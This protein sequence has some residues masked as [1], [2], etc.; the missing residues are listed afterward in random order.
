MHSSI[1]LLA[2]AVFAAL[3]IGQ[4][5]AA[6]TGLHSTGSDVS[7]GIDQAWTVDGGPAYVIANPGAIGW[8]GN[9][10]SS[11]WIS[12]DPSTFGGGGP[13]TYSTTFTATAGKNVLQG[14][15]AADDQGAIYL[16]GNLVFTGDG[17]NL[18]P[19]GYFQS[20]QITTGFTLGLN[21]LSVL[22]PNNIVG[23]NDGPTGLQLTAVPEL[24]T[25]AMMLAGFA[26]L[27]FVGY[28]RQKAT[29]AA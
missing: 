20:F 12:N 28:R 8:V 11:S 7:G 3:S 4:A 22:V 21:T 24:S 15:I 25:W 27:G 6:I 2:G 29:V 19:W 1:K 10:A 23:A 9:T 26:G 13:F 16:N 18:G 14:L 17:T 5:D